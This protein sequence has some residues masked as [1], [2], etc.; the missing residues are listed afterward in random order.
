[1]S[2]RPPTPP[3][4][5]NGAHTALFSSV[6]GAGYM[7]VLQ[8]CS[9]LATFS[10]NNVVQRV[11]SIRTVGIASDLELLSG[12]VLFLSRENLRMALLRGLK[13]DAVEVT[14]AERLQKDDSQDRISTWKAKRHR[15]KLVNLSYIPIFAGVLLA[16]LFLT[17]NEHFASPSRPTWALSLY[18]IA[19]V[20]E[21]L[22]EPMYVLVQSALLYDVRA[23]VE[24]AALMI[25]C[26]IA[27]TMTLSGYIPG[28]DGEKDVR[29]A[30]V[31]AWGQVAYA[32][33]LVLGYLWMLSKPEVW[34]KVCPEGGSLS[35]AL[36]IRRV[37]SSLDDGKAKATYFDKAALLVAGGF[38]TQSALKYLLTEGDR[39]LLL[40]MGRS[41]DEKGAYKMVSDLGSLIARILFQPLEETA[42]AYFSRTLS[43]IS[44]STTKSPSHRDSI[45]LSLSLLTLL[46]QLHMLLGSLFIFLAPNYTPVILLLLFGARK[47]TPQLVASLSLYCVY[48]PIMGLNGILEAFVQGVADGNVLRRQSLWLVICSG[49]FTGVAY[50]GSPLLGG[51]EALIVANCSNL[52]MRALFGLWFVRHFYENL[53]VESNGLQILRLVPGDRRLYGGLVVAYVVTKWSLHH[54]GWHG[55]KECLS[56]VAI[57]GACG[58]LVLTL[59]YTTE[60]HGLLKNLRASWKMIKGKTS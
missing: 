50:V 56:H 10:L 20:I 29:G 32:G 54:L 27:V 1:M 7:L 6:R 5:R 28:T 41:S 21:L 11:A 14:E 38:T 51:T 26:M 23:R 43:S 46:L 18:L 25:K 52:G 24:G 58:V 57:G 13:D 34:K 12:S 3:P 53:G 33:I 22:S 44:L 55:W 47:T 16:Y 30:E 48:V 8:L 60:R 17:Y 40:W 19:A 15:Q 39:I 4:P 36:M 42:R 59:M 2:P 35:N 45:T 37:D 31:Y 9:R 49:V